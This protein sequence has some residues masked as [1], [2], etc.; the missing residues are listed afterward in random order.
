MTFWEQH[1]QAEQVQRD[2]WKDVVPALCAYCGAVKRGVL[3]GVCPDC[4]PEVQHGE[5]PARTR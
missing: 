3:L 5:Q 2:E 4:T 1:A